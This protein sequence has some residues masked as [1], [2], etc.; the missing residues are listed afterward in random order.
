[1]KRDLRLSFPTRLIIRVIR[2]LPASIVFFAARMMGWIGFFF[3]G[4]SRKRAI[5]NVRTCLPCESHLYHKKIALRAFQHMVL[6]AVD[7]LRL[8]ETNSDAIHRINVRNKH[9]VIDAL[10]EGN[11]VVI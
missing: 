2:D 9:Y 1:M 11:G 3:N 7:L 6:L 10:K 4:V 8:P 5:N